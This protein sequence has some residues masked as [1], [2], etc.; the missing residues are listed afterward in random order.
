MTDSIDSIKRGSFSPNIP[1]C[2]YWYHTVLLVVLLATLIITTILK[3]MSMG[4]LVLLDYYVTAAIVGRAF[5]A[6]HSKI[7][8]DRKIF[9]IAV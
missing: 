9:F 6:R 5:H 2:R 3:L 8:E 1:L 7:C 4:R